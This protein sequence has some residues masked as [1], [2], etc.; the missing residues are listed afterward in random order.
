MT[1]SRLREDVRLVRLDRRLATP[2]FR[3]VYQRIR[4]AILDGT[5]PPGTSLPSSRSLA[6]QLSTARGTIELAYALLAGEDY[7]LGRRASGTVVN[8]RLRHLLTPAGGQELRRK[9]I[10][11]RR[12]PPPTVRPFQMGLP[13]LDAFPRKLWARLV[14]RRARSLSEIAMVSQDPAGYAPLRQAIAGYLAIARG[15]RCSTG[16]I[17]VTAGYQGAL[18]LITRT[19][20][21]PRDI[22]WFENPGYFRAREALAKAGAAIVPVPV[23]RDGLDISFAIKRCP[24]ARLAVVTPSHECP[25]GVTLSLPRRLEL[26]AWAAKMGAWIIEDDYDSE[27]RYR[28]HPLPALKS[29]DEADRVFYAGSFSKVLSPGLRLGYLV[30][31]WSELNRFSRDTELFSPI[32]SLLDQ[33][34]VADFMIDGHFARHLKRMRRLYAERRNVLVSALRNV[35]GD[36]IVLDVP[37]GGMHVIGRIPECRNDV[38]LT[39]SAQRGGLS[40]FALSSC[41]VGTSG[42]SGLLLSFTNIPVEAAER[43][44]QRLHQAI[45]GQ[46][47]RPKTRSTAVPPC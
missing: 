7:I 23:D 32:S 41:A 21:A 5:I 24:K 30:V 44:A 9:F 42:D 27:F 1:R 37:T 22:V 14:A 19:L 8:P 4:D 45:F 20:L 11:P 39:A 6:G 43:E 13:A 29:L 16:Q 46:L 31:P 25:L 35:F 2:L 3:Q 40:P 34:V 15:I 38:A 18:G 36:R 28:S 12:A 10:E 33:M 47:T 17:F 26:L